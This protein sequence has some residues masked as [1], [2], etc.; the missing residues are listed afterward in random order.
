MNPEEQQMTEVES[1]QL[2]TSMIN[3]ARTVL[4]KRGYYISS[5]DG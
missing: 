5:G 1:M 4:V 2:I 3:K